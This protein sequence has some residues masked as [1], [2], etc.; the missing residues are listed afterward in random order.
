MV[1]EEVLERLGCSREKIERWQFS[2]GKGCDR[3]K[4][5]GYSGRTCITEL[6][7]MSE[8]L[9]TLAVQKSSSSK[10]KLKARELGMRTL[11]EDGLEK[12]GRGATT[13]AE[14]LRVTQRDEV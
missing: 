11:R 2:E 3:C 7:L 1:N 10:I 6:M 14:V 13:L 9:R 4:E 5:T 12:A 8:P